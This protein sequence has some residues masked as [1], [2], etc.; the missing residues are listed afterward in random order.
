MRKK[1]Q[2]NS[3]AENVSHVP[4]ESKYRMCIESNLVS[5]WSCFNELFDWFI[6]KT[7]AIYSANRMQDHHR[8]HP[9]FPALANG[10]EF[11]LVH[12]LDSV[13]MMFKSLNEFV[14]VYLQ[15]PT[16]KAETMIC[17][18]LSVNWHCTDHLLIIWNAVSVTA[19]IYCGIHYLWTS[20]RL[21]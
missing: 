7:W 21:N 4:Q 8:R 5:L 6:L 17:V 12:C 16:N 9:R 20:E 3:W 15:N 13:W 18:I 1:N 14:P 10:S 19:V 11:P 2:I